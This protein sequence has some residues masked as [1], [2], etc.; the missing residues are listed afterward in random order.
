MWLFIGFMDVD[1]VQQVHVLVSHLV[2][3]HSTQTGFEVFCLAD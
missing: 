3:A 2:I 1:L